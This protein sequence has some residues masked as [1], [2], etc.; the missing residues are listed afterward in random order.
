MQFPVSSRQVT[1]GESGAPS[2]STALGTHIV[3]RQLIADSGDVN[4]AFRRSEYFVEAASLAIAIMTEGY[5]HR[6][7]AADAFVDF[8]NA[9]F[10]FCP[11]SL[12]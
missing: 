3:H 4:K 2:A 6:Q 12:L 7:V 9:G 10:A 1:L 5:S 11:L 8:R